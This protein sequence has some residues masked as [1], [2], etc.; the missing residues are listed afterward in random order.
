MGCIYTDIAFPYAQFPIASPKGS[1]LFPLIWRAIDR[2]ECNDIK[3][4][5]V[6]CDGASIN[7][8]LLKLYGDSYTYKTPNIYSSDSRP[9]LFF[10]DPP[11][12]LKTIRN[13][14]ANPCQ[15]LQVCR[16]HI[17]VICAHNNN[18]IVCI[19]LHMCVVF[20]MCFIV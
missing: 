12:L 9:L 16:L 17:E 15:N 6:T 20:Y 2:L 11:H 19:I 10:I 7:R 18:Q 5:G 13:G 1:D 4:L 8:R 3:V 14:F